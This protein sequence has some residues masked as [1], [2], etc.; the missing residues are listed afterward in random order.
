MPLAEE[1]LVPVAM[2]IIYQQGKFLM[3]LRDNIPGILYP[4]VWGL[5]GG[6]LE[7]GESPEIGLKRE[8]IEE[9][10]Y[11]VELVEKFACYGDKKIIRHIFHLPLLVEIEALELNEGWD[12]GLVSTE[13]ILRGYCYSERAG[14]ERPLGDTHQKI[15]LDFIDSKLT[16]ISF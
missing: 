5:F 12:L 14:E 11:S 8:L 2:A 7:L 9:I 4:G 16:S 1:T 15:L 10:N 6:H 3:Q 13:D